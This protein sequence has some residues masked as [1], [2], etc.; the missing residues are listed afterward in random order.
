MSRRFPSMSQARIRATSI[1]SDKHLSAS[2]QVQ[3]AA[4]V[5]LRMRSEDAEDAI[6][7]AEA[8]VARA[9]VEDANILRDAA[10]DPKA[11]P[12]SLAKASKAQHEAAALEVLERATRASVACVEV[13]SLAEAKWTGAMRRSAKERVGIVQSLC[14]E[15]SVPVRKATADLIAARS[16]YMAHVTALSLALDDSLGRNPSI[17]IEDS[18]WRPSLKSTVRYAPGGISDTLDL[19]KLAPALKADCCRHIAPTP[20]PSDMTRQDTEEMASIASGRK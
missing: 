8:A 19:S 18:T 3:G 9:K 12:A 13:Q 14:D 7:S 15:S 1:P 5:Q 16:T 11:T 10:R 2:M 6:R 4:L 17:N 20:K